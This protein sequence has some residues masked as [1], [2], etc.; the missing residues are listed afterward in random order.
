MRR[1]W[2]CRFQVPTRE[3]FLDF[4]VSI[5]SH[6]LQW[7]SSASPCCFLSLPFSLPLSPPLG[8]SRSEDC[9]TGQQPTTLWA[10]RGGREG[11]LGLTAKSAAGNAHTKLRISSITTVTAVLASRERGEG[12][13]RLSPFVRPLWC[14]STKR[15][16]K[17]LLYVV[18]HPHPA[19]KA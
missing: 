17:T 6:L 2:L 13:L 15:C 19:Q 8:K 1:L 11:I 4:S 14:R 3:A 10:D 18:Q 5:P 16:R 7:L 12:R 9:K